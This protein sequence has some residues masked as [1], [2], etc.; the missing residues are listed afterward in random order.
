MD[1]IEATIQIREKGFS[2]ERLPVIGLTASLMQNNMQ[3]YLSA[4]MND[5]LGKPFILQ[6]LAAALARAVEKSS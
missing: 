4:G 2:P 5:C 6:E 3:T 1:G